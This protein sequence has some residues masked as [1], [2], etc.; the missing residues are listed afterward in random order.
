MAYWLR[1]FALYRSDLPTSG[2][3]ARSERWDGSEWVDF[4]DLLRM[5]LNGDTSLDE[6]TK[7]VAEARFPAAF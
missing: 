4:P 6:I 7:T 5:M 2:G 3:D 1:G